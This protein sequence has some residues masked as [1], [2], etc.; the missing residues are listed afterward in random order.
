GRG[1]G[2]GRGEGV[3]FR[4]H[5][6]G[7]SARPAVAPEPMAGGPVAAPAEERAV[8][9]AV[10]AGA[11]PTSVYHRA[12]LRP[13]LHLAGPCIVEEPSSTTV[14]VPGATLLVD[15][16]RNL[17]VTLAAEQLYGE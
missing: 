14:V 2:E 17:V 4:V 1:A 7:V 11:V 6:I 16:F 3:A 15:G 8:L 10:D 13:G 12:T 9:F 5:G